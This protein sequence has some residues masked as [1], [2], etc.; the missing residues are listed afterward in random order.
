V[1]AG[2]EITP[3]RLRNSTHHS[4]GTSRKLGSERSWL[5]NTSPTN[6]SDDRPGIAH[7]VNELI[8]AFT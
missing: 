3:T 1:P 2:A 6:G 4:V 8:S 7:G 5:K